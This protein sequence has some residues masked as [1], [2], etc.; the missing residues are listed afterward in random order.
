MVLVMEMIIGCILFTIMVIWGNKKNSLSGLHNMPMALQ[1]R[2]ASLTQYQDVKVVHT[3]ERILKKIP[4]LIVLAIIFVVLIYASGARTFIQGFVN[5]FLIWF[6]IKLYV[7]FVLQCGWLAHTPS[8]WIPG[9]ED[10]KECYQDYGFYMKSI[11]GS[12]AAGLIVA[13]MVGLAIAAVI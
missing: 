6:V 11:P 9:T 4:V 13:A 7:V 3:K 12:L 10:M 5:T 8:V 2:V 1:K